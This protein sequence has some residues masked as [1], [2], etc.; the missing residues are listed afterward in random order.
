MGQLLLDNERAMRKLSKVRM[1]RDHYARLYFQTLSQLEETKWKLS[2]AMNTIRELK[3][4]GIDWRLCD[5]LGLCQ[6][7]SCQLSDNRNATD[8]INSAGFNEMDVILNIWQ[9]STH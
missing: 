1:R 9:V 7:Q 5:P 8:L 3:T 4:Q 2:R 6:V